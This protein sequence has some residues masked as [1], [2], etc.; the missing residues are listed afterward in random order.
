MSNQ[1]NKYHLKFITQERE[2]YKN[3]IRNINMSNV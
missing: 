1:T 3:P 2:S